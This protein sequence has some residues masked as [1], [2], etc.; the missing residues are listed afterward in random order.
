MPKISF[1]RH[2]HSV[3]LVRHCY[4]PVVKRSVAVPVGSLR[5]DADP[6]DVPV[7]IDLCRD[8]HLSMDDIVRVQEWL[9]VHGDREAAQ[10][11][12]EKHRQLEAALREE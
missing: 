4:S 5:V 10:R 8:A 7:C 6:A 2:R 12:R 1:K 11:R 9:H 3:R